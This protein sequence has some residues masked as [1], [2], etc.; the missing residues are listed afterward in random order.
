MIA[1]GKL[2]ADDIFNWTGPGVF[3][4]AVLSYLER[5]YGTSW[6]TDLHKKSKSLVIGDLLLLTVTAFS[7]GMLDRAGSTSHPDA[8]VRHQFEGSWRHNL[9]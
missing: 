9:G 2:S 7:A 3:T 8:L 1:K 6:R 5:D 4:D